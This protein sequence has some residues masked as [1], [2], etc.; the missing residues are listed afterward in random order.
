MED[1][2]KITVVMHIWLLCLLLDQL[3]VFDEMASMCVYVIGS[4]TKTSCC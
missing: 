2:S 4:P 1:T 3:E